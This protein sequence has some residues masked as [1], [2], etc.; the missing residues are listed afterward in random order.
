MSATKPKIASL[1][2]LGKKREIVAP[3]PSGFTYRIRPLNLERHALSGGLPASLR[4]VAAKGSE[5]VNELL[6]AG[7]DEQIASDGSSV[8]SYLDSLVAAVI[9]EPSLYVEGTTTNEVSEDAIDVVPPVDYQW[10]LA[11]AM[12]E[13]DEDGDGRRLWGR[14]PLSRWATFRVFHGCG[15]DCDG[16]SQLLDELSAA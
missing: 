5:G 8:K 13:H 2:D 12:G 6:S 3:G 4:A 15:E 11:I 14:E 7:S 16:C 9:V 1:A 10:A